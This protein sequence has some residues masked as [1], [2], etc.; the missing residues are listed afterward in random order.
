MVE[1][2][3]DFALVIGVNDYPAYGVGGNDLEGAIDDAREFAAWLTDQD[4]GG[5]LPQSHC[6]LVLSTPSPLRPEQGQV[7]DALDRLW[8][9]ADDVAQPRRFY[10]Y[11]S[12]H[13]HAEQI[14]DVS[15]CMAN[16][17]FRRRQAALSSSEYRRLIHHC[18]RFQEVVVF[19]DC[20]RLREYAAAGRGSELN[21]PRHDA[22]AGGSRHF[23]AYATEFQQAAFE[24]RTGERVRGHLTAALLEAVRGAAPLHPD[25]GVTAAELK[26]YL[27]RRVPEMADRNGQRQQVE[28]VSSLPTEPPARF[29]ARL[30]GVQPAATANCRIRFSARRRGPIR[31]EA[32]TLQ[33]LREGAVDTAPWALRLGIGYH[34]LADLATGEEHFFVQRALDGVNDVHF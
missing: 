12:G 1:Q 10:F 27:E 11:F 18:L 14:D 30:P 26:A 20:C 22:T 23:I 5:G 4:T 28:V 34:R 21:C 33:V 15:L 7:D 2:S 25:G 31:L 32:P 13:G 24:G 29:G 16:W 17:S 9:A 3:N 19:L 8:Q 6:E